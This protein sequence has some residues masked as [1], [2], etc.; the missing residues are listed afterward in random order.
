M[1]RSRVLL[2]LL[3]LAVPA[4]ASAEGLRVDPPTLRSEASGLDVHGS[5]CRTSALPATGAG[6]VRIE[7]IGE[8]GQV[9]EVAYARLSRALGGRETGCGFYGRSTGWRLAAGEQ[10]RVC[11]ANSSACP[12]S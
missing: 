12:K 7:R 4:C 11:L 6:S 3:L 8:T 10:V 1:I 2:A 9:S 5:V